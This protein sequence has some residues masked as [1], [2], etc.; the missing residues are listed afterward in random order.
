M[1]ENARAAE[2]RLS[3]ATMAAIEELVNPRTVSGHRYSPAMQA[4]IDTE[5]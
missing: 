3:A 2:V 5:G 4:A 1:V